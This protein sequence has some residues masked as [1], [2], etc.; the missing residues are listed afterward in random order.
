[1]AHTPTVPDVLSSYQEA[2]EA[3]EKLRDT[4]DRLGMTKLR[5]VAARNV[6]AIIDSRDM[7]V[8]LT[9]PRELHRPVDVTAPGEV[10]EP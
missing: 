1:M 2:L 7:Y 10:L 5:D 8:E 6:A 4:F 3:S 9:Q